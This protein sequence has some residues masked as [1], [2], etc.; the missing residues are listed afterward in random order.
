MG[1][2][3]DATG[4]ILEMVSIAKLGSRRDM[5]EPRTLKLEVIKIQVFTIFMQI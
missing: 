4:Q 1:N 2:F 5:I 3:C